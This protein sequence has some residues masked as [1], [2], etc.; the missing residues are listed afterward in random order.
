MNDGDRERLD[1]HIADTH[2]KLG[3]ELHEQLRELRMELKRDHDGLRD[4]YQEHIALIGY[5]NGWR[6]GVDARLD[7]LE[8]QIDNLMLALIRERPARSKGG[9]PPAEKTS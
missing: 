9:K 1:A 8:K 5:L 3:S 7:R 4:K 6:T 2:R